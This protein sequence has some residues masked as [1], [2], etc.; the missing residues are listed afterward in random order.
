MVQLDRF[1]VVERHRP[2]LGDFA[3]RPPSVERPPLEPGVNELR[4]LKLDL[5]STCNIACDYCFVDEGKALPGPKVMTEK[6]V[7]D[8]INWFADKTQTQSS[9]V[10]LFGGE[11]L[12]NKK[13]F[14][15]ACR[16]I[17]QLR[18]SGQDIR[19]QIISNAMLATDEVCQRLSEAEATIMVSVDGNVKN[20]D[21]HR[22]DHQGRPTYARV[23]NGL[24][25]LQK[26]LPADKIWA[27]ATMTPGFSQLEYFDSLV[28]IGIRQISLGYI[29]D[30][31]PPEMTVEKFK[32]EI[33][34]LMIQY[35]SLIDQHVAIRIH[36]LGTYLSLI[37]GKQGRGASWPRY[38]CG[39]ATRIITVAPDGVLYPCEHA[40][41]AR[42][43]RDWS[44]GTVVDGISDDLVR[45]FLGETNR[46]NKGCASCGKASLCDQG[47]RVVSAV[48]GTRDQCHAQ[49]NFLSVLWERA[50]FWYN[51]LSEERP[52][53]L[54]RIVDD[55]LYNAIRTS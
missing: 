32:A 21:L 14:A 40:A 34:E 54:L 53:T 22:R 47:C 15:A 12:L 5:S 39:A 26:H 18:A 29:D 55:K 9:V 19:L 28:A 23:M 20:H 16:E 33:D 35:A 52:S 2:S 36:P 43:T 37:Y 46:T 41:T 13:G 30:T 50:Q 3:I 48:Q 6:T 7:I 4:T 38:D 11:P 45:K 31:P 8:A 44:L 42:H 1:Q 24:R 51:R 25:N 49:E 17:S 10:V 27:R